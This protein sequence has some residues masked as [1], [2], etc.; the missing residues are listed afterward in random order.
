MKLSQQN[1]NLADYLEETELVDY[2]TGLICQKA[3]LL[4]DSCK[5]DTDKINAAYEFVRDRIHHSADINGRRVTKTASEVLLYGEGMCYAKTLLLAALLRSRGI[6]TGFCY[7]RL[8][9]DSAEV[10]GY[11]IHA[12]NAVYIADKKAWVRIDARGNTDGR[13]ARFYSDDPLR[14]QLAYT[15]R[16]NV[17]EIEYPGIYARHPEQILY[18]LLHCKN[19][20]EMI[21][22]YLPDSL[23]D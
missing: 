19:C 18:S 22:S 10:K 2:S 15:A 23:D 17:G 12:L 14:E 9:K 6:H 7:Q 3:A 21:A 1:E 20:Q 5:T 16:S 4:F 8:A 13:N 11:D